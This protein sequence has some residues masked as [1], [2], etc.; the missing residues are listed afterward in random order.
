MIDKRVDY[1]ADWLVIA[2]WMDKHDF[3][4]Q[5]FDVIVKDPQR[6]LAVLKRRAD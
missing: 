5:H 1:L 3:I 2:K 6:N 4:R